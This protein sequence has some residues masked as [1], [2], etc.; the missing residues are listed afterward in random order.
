[1][2]EPPGGALMA[3][4]PFTTVSEASS[5]PPTA[6]AAKNIEKNGASIG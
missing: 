2:T 5:C 6:Q 4:E 3:S 1:M